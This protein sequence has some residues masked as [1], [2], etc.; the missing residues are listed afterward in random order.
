MN[1]VFIISDS[2]I[3]FRDE[4]YLNFLNIK[5]KEVANI[6]TD[7]NDILILDLNLLYTPLYKKFK[8]LKGYKVLSGFFSD[9]GLVEL[10]ERFGF[11]TVIIKPFYIKEL[12]NL[13]EN[14]L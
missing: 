13:L 12:N 5:P 1:K 8:I 11:D 9:N 2:N 7:D 10:S 4:D 14:R 6:K 3:F